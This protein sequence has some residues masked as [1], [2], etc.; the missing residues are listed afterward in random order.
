MT[1]LLLLQPDTTKYL[2]F[3]AGPMD[4]MNP[5]TMSGVAGLLELVAVSCL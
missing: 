1:G 4:S 5:M 2:N 3:P